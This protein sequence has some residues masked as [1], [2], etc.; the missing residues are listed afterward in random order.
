MQYQQHFVPNLRL[1]LGCKVVLFELYQ[2]KVWFAVQ[3]P[4]ISF[5][6]TNEFFE[7]LKSREK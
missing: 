6:K 5:L 1:M 2:I 3:L 4:Q 7:I